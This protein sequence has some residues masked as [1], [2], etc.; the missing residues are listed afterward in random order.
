MT[1]CFR[2]NKFLWFT[3]LFTSSATFLH[4]Q[5]VVL[6]GV[7]K[8]YHNQQ[9]VAS[10][11]VQAK[12][13]SREFINGGYVNVQ[14]DFKAVLANEKGEYQLT[15]PADEYVIEVSSVGYIKKSKFMRLQ[16]NTTYDVDLSERVNQLDDVEVRTQKADAN[17]KSLEMSAVKLNIQNLK[18]LPV[19]FGEGDIIKA[20]TLQPG[21]T[22]AGEGT[23]GFSVR[24]GR[25]DQNLVLLDGAPLFNTSHLLGF[26]TSINPET[27][28]SATLY[29]GGISARYGGRLSSLLDM[30]TKTSTDRNRTVLSLGPVSSNG[31]IQRPFANKK[32][33]FM[34]A[35]RAAYPN[36]MISAFPKRFSGSKAAFYDVNGSLQYRIGSKQSVALTVY[37]SSDKFKFPE[38]TS[39][40]WQ[41]QIATAQWNMQVNA[42]LSVTAK[43]LLS[44]YTY[45]VN[46]LAQNYEYRFESALRH[47]EARMDWMF[48]PNDKNKVEWG[49][50][51]INYQFSPADIQPTATMSVVNGQFSPKEYGREAA[52]YLSHEWQ[53]LSR[54]SMQLGVRYSVFSNLGPGKVFVYNPNLPRTADNIIDTLT[55][56]SGQSTFSNGGFEPRASLKI[57]LSDA[58]SIKFSYNRTRQYLHLISNTTAISPIDYWKLSN[59]YIPPQ[60]ADQWAAGYYRNFSENTYVTYVEGFY[61]KMRQLVDYKDGASLL[62]NPHLETELLP[63]EGHSYGV[64]VSLQKNK[65]LFTGFV[66][67]T[68]SR[69][70]VAMR[71]QF[72]IDQVNNGQYFSSAFDMPHNLTL[73]GNWFLGSGWSVV[74]NFVYQTGR[75]ATF[76]DGQYTLN[77]SLI[78]NYSQRNGSRMPDYHRLDLSFSYDGRRTKEQRRYS[79]VNISFYNLYARKNPYSIFF[80]QYGGY[81]KAYRLSVLGALIPSVTLTLH[82]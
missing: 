46:G 41:S 39:Y 48:L 32:G 56:G 45:G 33:A 77:E 43:A 53:P 54:I 17:V 71:P 73:S 51:V 31:L 13:I 67:Y 29:E 12:K 38:D 61:K 15:L 68:W 47:H 69:A 9:V 75:P 1:N 14:R 58:Q 72:V 36:L 3:I 42:K 59:R 27:I 30:T 62:L 44:H 50:N 65:G 76:P 26:F 52:A 35:A 78:F 10:A 23:G 4:A 66:S 8:D 24:G 74:T 16:Q 49:A 40:F 82:W 28:Q 22:T 60:I 80:R 70:L 6:S 55:Y 81:P 37:Q 5:A 79:I 21:V 19:V 34:L 64:E 25:T 11:N 7:I 2:L 20:L 57:E 63:A 18:K